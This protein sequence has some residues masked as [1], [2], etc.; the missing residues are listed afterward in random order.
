[1]NIFNNPGLYNK[2][3]VALAGGL[4]QLALVLSDNVVT[5]VEWITVALA[6]LTA[7]GVAAVKNSEVK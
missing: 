7:A 2:F 6:A 3:F 5:N 1:M 4:T